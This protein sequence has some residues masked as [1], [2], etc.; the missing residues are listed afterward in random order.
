MEAEALLRAGKLDEAV[1][2]LGLRLRDNPSDTRSRTFLFELLCFRGDY[3][4]ARKHLAVLGGES[5]ETAGGALLYEGALQAEEIRQDM[6][7]RENCPEPLPD[8]AGQ[9]TGK[10]NGAPFLSLTDADPR[11]GPRLELFAAG[12]YLWIPFE[13]I[14]SVEIKPPQRLRDLLWAPAF[15]R[16]GPGFQSH[17]LGEVLLPVI[18]PLTSKHP[19]GQVVLGRMTEWCADER[20]REYPYGQKMLLVD[21]E[22]VA[23]LEVRTL[24]I[25][26]ANRV[27]Q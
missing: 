6:F 26:Q 20:G 23:L 22:E 7:E 25:T 4:R 24:E 12:E 3:A 2:D 27:A 8:K 9:L 14:A 18:S 1:E 13:H 10:L 21:G 11:I 19:D 17:D 15:V 5:N 16:T